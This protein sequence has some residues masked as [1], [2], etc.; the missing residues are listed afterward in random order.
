MKNPRTGSDAYVR[1]VQARIRPKAVTRRHRFELSSVRRSPLWRVAI[2]CRETVRLGHVHRVRGHLTGIS[3]IDRYCHFTLRNCA[4]MFGTNPIGSG[5][6]EDAADED[7]PW[8][9][10]LT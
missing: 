7:S 4:G 8:E 1:S 6:R 5:E 3:R 2:H 9:S 10:L